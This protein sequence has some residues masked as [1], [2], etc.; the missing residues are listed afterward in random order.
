MLALAKGPVTAVARFPE[1][2]NNI[3]ARRPVAGFIESGAVVKKE[4]AVELVSDNAIRLFSRDEIRFPAWRIA[5]AINARF[6]N[7]S[8]A[9][10]EKTIWVR[11]PDAHRDAPVEFIAQIQGIEIR[12]EFPAQIIV[13]DERTGIVVVN[14]RTNVSEVGFSPGKIVVQIAEELEAKARP[15]SR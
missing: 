8:R 5:E 7:A 1:T 2:R 15:S 9:L 4:S 12:S 14:V 10:D 3:A 6:P 11:I 13:I